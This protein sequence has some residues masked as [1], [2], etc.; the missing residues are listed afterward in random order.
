MESIVS[1]LQALNCPS[2]IYERAFKHAASLNF[3]NLAEL[4]LILA[5]LLE[6]KL[7]EIVPGQ[8]KIEPIDF[9]IFANPL[10]VI[11]ARVKE[12]EDLGELDI[13]REK[14]FRL[15]YKGLAERVKKAKESNIAY[16]ADG[17]YAKFL[18]HIK[19][20]NATISQKSNESQDEV[21]TLLTDVLDVGS[22]VSVASTGDEAIATQ[23]TASGAVSKLNSPLEEILQG[24]QTIGLNDKTFDR[25]E[26][27]AD[28]IRKVMN[29][30]YGINEVNDTITD[31]LIK[32]VTNEIMDDAMVMYYS[33]TYGKNISDEEARKLKAT[34][35]EKLEY[36]GIMDVDLGGSAA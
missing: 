12:M 24:P 4:N 14:L 25:Y 11:R 27:L 3:V 1:K 6:K 15:N 5:F 31:N 32:L 33:I 29:D 17:K 7:I 28:G 16:K 20:F 18:F 26:K 19:D 10:E 2:E 34:I 8:M 22:S 35:K 36:M 21:E 30:V 13:Y 9:T 23:Y